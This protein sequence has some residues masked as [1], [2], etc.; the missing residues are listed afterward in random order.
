MADEKLAVEQE[1]AA[2]GQPAESELELSDNEKLMA[3]LKEAVTVQREDLGG[4]R[5]K[6]TVT[7]PR[8]TIEGRMSKE[9]AELK[10]EAAIPGFRKGHA[11]LKLVE[12]RF[13]SDVGEQLKSQMLSSGY[14]A[15]VEKEEIKPLGDPMIWCKVKE[16]RVGE[17][18]KPRQAEVEK[19]VSLDQALEHLTL[20]KDGPLTFACE[21]EVKPVFELPS[22]SKIPVKRPKVSIRDADVDEA[23]AHLR[24]RDATFE[25]VEKGPVQFNDMIYADLKLMIGDEQIMHE[26]NTDLAARPMRIR[27]IPLPELGNAL[28]GA[29]IGDTVKHEATVPDDHDSSDYRGKTARFEITIHEIKRMV[30]PPV[31]AEFLES[32]GFESESELR[33][34]V[35]SELE[36]RL[37]RTIKGRMLEQIGDYL[38]EKTQLEIPTGLS[39]RQADRSVARR[40]IELYQRG[41]PE[42]EIAKEADAMRS[43]AR[44][45]TARD[46]KLYF[47][48][49]K[50]GDDREVGVNEEEFN[51]AVA[52]MARRSGKRFDRVRDELSKGDGLSMLYV[53]IRENKVLEQLLSDAEISESTVSEP[54][55]DRVPKVE[56]RTPPAPKKAPAS[57]DGP[58][59]TA[60]VAVPEAVKKSPKTA[61][62]PKK[63]TPPKGEKS[64][65]KKT[66]KKKKG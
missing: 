34:A 12:K 31:D 37:E 23:V 1:E 36:S 5:M 62:S 16:D 53:Q 63:P 2:D 13:A 45:Q 7:V 19:L 33:D 47:I 65:P 3:E 14:L 38:I 26:Q 60:S 66:A 18:G 46:L 43:A 22:L 52:E 9:F 64:S 58:K 10:R 6:L 51:A 54:E 32:A 44:E 48:V 25:P 8:D 41:V 24:T 4:L 50:I 55:T 20:P 17:D 56:K 49:E 59:K 29:K 39:Q 42:T 40:M 15:A 21:L 61:A 27:G 30:V 28:K 11:P 57:A 35:R